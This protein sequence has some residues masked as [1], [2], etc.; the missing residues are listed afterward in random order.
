MTILATIPGPAIPFARPRF[1][2]GRGYQD[3][4]YAAWKR[5]A[6]LILRAAGGGRPLSRQP[7]ALEVTLYRERPKARPEGVDAATWKMGIACLAIG[8]SD[9]D[10]HV[11]AVADALVDSGVIADDRWIVHIVATSWYAPSFGAVGVDV[12]ITPLMESQ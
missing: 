5:C 4:A 1:S 7:L 9:L 3:P 2:A 8:R 11:K 10:N 12:S 6:A